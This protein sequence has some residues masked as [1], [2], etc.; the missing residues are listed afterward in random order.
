MAEAAVRD[1]AAEAREVVAAIEAG[2]PVPFAGLDVIACRILGESVLFAVDMERDP[3]QRNHRRGRFYEA[4]ELEMI[5]RHLPPGGVFADIGANTGNHSLFVARFLHPARVI[6]FEPNPR[7]WRLLIAN[8]ALNGCLDRCDLS[9][10]GR[11]V[12]AAAADGF[13]MEPR[14]RNLGAAKMLAGEGAISV[15][16]GD[17]ALAG[18]RPDVIKIDVEGMELDVLAG[19]SGTL[20]RARP[21]LLVEVDDANEPAFRDWAASAGYEI[22]ATNQRYRANRNHLLRPARGQN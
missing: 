6:P 1:A 22:A 16:T 7:A 8:M 18:L 20:A 17:S 15:I 9:H 12:G 4:K 14:E 2:G 19:L 21:A 5:R 13:G 11:G 3:V 10:L